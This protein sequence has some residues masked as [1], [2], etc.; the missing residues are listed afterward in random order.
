MVRAGCNNVLVFQAGAADD[1]VPAAAV[2][3]TRQSYSDASV[4][5]AAHP[6]PLF[7]VFAFKVPHRQAMPAPLLLE[8]LQHRSNSAVRRPH[9]HA[10]L[11]RW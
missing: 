7:A 11:L 3:G 6:V 2:G 5:A 10:R 4:P 1:G 9:R 8:V